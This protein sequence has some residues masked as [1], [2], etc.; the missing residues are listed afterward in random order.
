VTFCLQS[1]KDDLLFPSHVA[2]DHLFFDFTVRVIGDRKGDPPSFRGPFAQG[3]SAAR[4]VY[5]SSGTMAGQA[6]SYWTRER[7]S[8]SHRSP[9]T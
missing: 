9:G 1:G 5:V 8:R 3:P 6:N 2:D 4:F 7:K